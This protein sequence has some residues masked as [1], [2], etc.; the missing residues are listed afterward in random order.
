MN[1]IKF[2]RKIEFIDLTK[3]E[4]TA[5]QLVESKIEC[6]AED[7]VQ[8]ATIGHIFT[9]NAGILCVLLPA[10]VSGQNY[11]LCECYIMHS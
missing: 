4:V 7:K 6:V 10:A 5:H 1:A 8:T 11:H 9:E 3:E 2:Q